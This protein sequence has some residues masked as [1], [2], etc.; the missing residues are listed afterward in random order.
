MAICSFVSDIVREVFEACGVPDVSE[1]QFSAHLTIAK[2]PY[3]KRV[4]LTGLA[5]ELYEDF[6]DKQFGCEQ[7]SQ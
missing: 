4:G 2:M 7:V 5:K 6:E 1:H 3:R